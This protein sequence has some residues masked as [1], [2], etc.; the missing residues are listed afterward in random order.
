MAF[1]VH[2]GRSF[3]NKAVRWLET[4]YFEGLVNGTLIKKNS[5]YIRKFRRDR[6]QS[7]ILL[8]ASSDTTKY[9]RISSYIR[10]PFLIYDFAPDLL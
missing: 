5:S 8:T 3:C 9:L 7:H 2:N 4:R 1:E 6:V 10:K